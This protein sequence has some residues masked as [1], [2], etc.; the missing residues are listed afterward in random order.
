VIHGGAFKNQK[1]YCPAIIAVALLFS[2]PAFAQTAPRQVLRGHVPGVVARLIPSGRLAATTNLSLTIGL[3]LRNEAAL[4]ELLAQLYDPNSTNYH[5]F[6][7]PPEFAAR[8]GPTEQDYQSVMAFAETNGFTVAN[9]YS[10]RMVLDV[11]GRAGDIERT[12]QVTLRTYRHPTEN[13]DFFAP[14]TEPSVPADVRVADVWGL[15]DYGRPHPLSHPAVPLITQP[16]GGSGPSGYYAGKDFRN[17]Y[18]RGTALTGVGQTVGLLEFDGYHTKD[19]TNYEH[20]IGMTNLVPL[21]NV[22]LNGYNGGAG[23]AND[24]VCLDIEMA[25]AM[26]PGL[27]DVIVYEIGSSGSPGTILSRMASDNLA[28]QMSSSWTWTGGPTT[29]IDNTFRQMAV[30]GQSFFQAAGD[31]D[32]YTGGEALDNSGQTTAPVDS[33]NITTVGGTTL[34]MNGSGASWSSETVWNYNQYGGQYANEGSGGGISTYYTI[35]YWQTNVNM[36]A[37]SGSTTFRNVPDVALTA[38]QVYVAYNNGSSGGLAGTSCAAPLWAGFCALVNQQSVTFSGT[39]VG[40]L[41]PALYAI[42][43]ATN[44]A[45][46]FHDINT[47][48]NIGTNTPGLFNAV[49]GYDLCTG[50]G[51]PNGTNLI[52]ALA[53]QLSPYVLTPPISQSAAAGGN[54]TFTTSI[55]GHPPF[56]YRWL[57]NGTNLPAG[58]N[59][60]GTA[61]NTLTIT[62]V[63]TNN[64]GNYSLAVA[65]GYGSVT[66]SIAVL[67]VGFAPAIS[68]QPASQTVPSGGSAMF[69]ATATGSPPLIYQWQENGVNISN[70]AGIFGATSNLL[71]LTA[72]TTNS[73]GNYSVIVTNFYGAATSSVAALTVTL[74]PSITGSSLANQTVQCGSNN[75]SFVITAAG[76]PPLNIQWS[77]DGKPVPNATNAGFFL[78]NLHLPNHTVAVVV[79]NPYGSV[80]NSAVVTVQDTLA[81]VITLNGTNPLF[82]ELGG[83][84]N[85]PGASATDLCAGIIGIMASGAVNTNSVSTNTV[86]YTADDGDGNI[87]TATRTVIVQDTTSPTI[88]WSFTNLVLAA[89]TNCTASMPDVTGTNYILA[90][91]LSGSLTISET[92]TNNSILQLGTN[93]IVITVAD[94]SGNDAYSTNTIV[95]Q[96]ETPPVILC[97]P[98]SQ[99][100]TVGDTVDFNVAAIACTPLAYQWFYNSAA[101]TNETNSTLEIDNVSTNA[102]GD[103][104]VVASAFGGSTT[105]AVVTLTVNLPPPTFSNVAAVPGGGFNLS[106]G[107]TPGQTYVLEVKSDLSPTSVWEAIA[108]NTIG[109]GG[110]WQFNDGQATNYQQRFYRIR[111][112]Q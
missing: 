57:F 93:T 22:K 20:T 5:K 27:S 80:T 81:P 85:D 79:T 30:Q 62:S 86:T 1:F 49:S 98:R 84:F 76:T 101:L 65:N 6:L 38:D 32:A 52:Y 69:S 37:N 35:P 112:A 29:T 56:N 74:P 108:T 89:D 25:I 97:Q 36:T 42:G 48:S 13:R 91:D 40:F 15:S 11:T 41:N 64:A 70:G 94:A 68:T 105:S 19:I 14:D 106:L 87:A 12:F 55:G 21:T 10:N 82:I 109:A 4:N 51:T 71:T 67:S 61:T 111:Q 60:S 50:W 88:L 53:P 45:A 17:A 33:T 63:T 100:N 16:L 59:L 39:T 47:G 34:Y 46:C 103:Y 58:G 104:S 2:F 18:A 44:Y 90:T 75:L 7:K 23:P 99:T 72:V 3:P 66:S 28:E 95:V 102:A 78:T 96:D 24:E 8:F 31:S 107:G 9:T 77:L 110:A 73:D 92:P 83:A 43:N 54:V 26:A